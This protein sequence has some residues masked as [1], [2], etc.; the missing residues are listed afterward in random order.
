M[1]NVYRIFTDGSAIDN[2]GAGGWGVVGMQ[3]KNRWESSGARPWTTIEEMELLAAVEALRPLPTDSVIELRSDSQY[4]IYGMRTFVF[5]WQNQGWRNR[6]GRS[7]NTAICG[8]SS[9]G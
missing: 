2:P 4:L 3:G 9:S 5:R 7:C 8:E 1:D 6:G